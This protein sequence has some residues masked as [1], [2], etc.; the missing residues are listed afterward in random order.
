MIKELT[1]LGLFCPSTMKS[2]SRC[3][4]DLYTEISSDNLS[5][6]L[7]VVVED[8]IF[9]FFPIELKNSVIDDDDFMVCD[10][11]CIT[12]SNAAE[13]L[14]CSSIFSTMMVCRC[15]SMR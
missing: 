4:N 7:V 10:F 5:S 6:I 2:Y 14:P 9:F 3:A 11:R 8:E 1:T 15:N 13:L 12:G